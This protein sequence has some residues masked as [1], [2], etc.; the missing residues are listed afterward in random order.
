MRNDPLQRLDKRIQGKNEGK[1]S[2]NKVVPS[3]PCKA[4]NCQGYNS[5]NYAGDIASRSVN[6]FPLCLALY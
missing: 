2:G 6:W 5:I 3:R 4:I 1:R